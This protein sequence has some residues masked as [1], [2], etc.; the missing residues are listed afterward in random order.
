MGFCP[1]YE[2][3]EYLL[4]RSFI[5]SKSIGHTEDT[6]KV[7]Y[8]ALFNIVSDKNKEDY[9]QDIIKIMYRRK[10]NDS[11]TDY[12]FYYYNGYVYTWSLLIY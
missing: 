5:C 8:S 3:M 1:F 6:Y 7:L 11:W 2:N 4:L 10:K 12:N 9:L